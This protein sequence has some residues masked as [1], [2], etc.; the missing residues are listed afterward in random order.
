MLRAIPN[1][2][3]FPLSRNVGSFDTEPADCEQ[4][5]PHRNSGWRCGP[6]GPAGR[7]PHHRGEDTTP[8]PKILELPLQVISQLYDGLPREIGAPLAPQ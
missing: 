1:P 7:T 5:C 2:L 6:C 8:T 4:Q 3:A